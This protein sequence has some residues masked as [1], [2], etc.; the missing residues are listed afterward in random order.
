MTRID[1]LVT[2]HPALV[3]LLREMGLVGDDVQVIPHV[4][5]PEQI[6]GRVVGGALPLH[7]AAEAEAIVSLDLSLRPE[8]RGRELTLD[9]LKER[10]VGVS[11]YKVTRIG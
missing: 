1:I 11:I 4:T 7:M 9:E 6:R 2:R 10:F 5:S 3:Q 8:D